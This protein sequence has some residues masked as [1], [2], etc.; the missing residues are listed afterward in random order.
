M[1][2][3]LLFLLLFAAGAVCLA[4]A[5]Q[6]TTSVIVNV[7][8][9]QTKAALHGLTADDF[10]ARAH[11]AN[12]QVVTV[13]PVFRNRVLILVDR[14]GINQD[15]LRDVADLVREAPP[16]MPVAFGVF[17]E[18]ALFTRRFITDSDQLSASLDEV[19]THSADIGSRPALA[20][21][22]LQ[23][24]D[25]FGPHQPGDTILLVTRGEA[26]ES[27]AR[28]NQLRNAFRRRGTR[29]QLLMGVLA[30]PSFHAQNGAQIFAGWDAGE[31][32]S[33]E[34]IRLANNTGGVLMGFMNSEW[35]QAA[36]AG[37][38]LS[39]NRQARQ[40]NA[41]KWTLQL[42]DAGNDVPPAELFYPERLSPCTSTEVAA[43]PHET[44]PR[45]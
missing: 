21:A 39:I 15:S 29:L 28:M 32:F 25:L 2:I 22:L 5:Q 23:A 34:L 11:K 33:D 8:D 24:V 3:S 18:R 13:K 37:Y 26:R 4:N 16:G 43:L 7:F 12:L 35:L 38:M 40:N 10:A 17:A 14:N 27:R 20:P 42:R 1:R 31:N 6:C 45:P 36:T 9:A 19:V 41:Q 30:A 44:Q